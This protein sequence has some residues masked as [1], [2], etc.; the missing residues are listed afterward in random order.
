MTERSGGQTFLFVRIA[1]GDTIVVQTEGDDA[2]Q[3]GDHVPIQ[4]NGDLCHLFDLSGESVGKTRLH[5][6][7]NTLT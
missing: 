5:Q 3:V 4:I 2:S 7:Q 1:G 6:L